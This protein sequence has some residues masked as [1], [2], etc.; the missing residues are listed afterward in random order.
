MY[1]KAIQGIV[2]VYAKKVENR[3]YSL[4]QKNKMAFGNLK[5]FAVFFYFTPEPNSSW[6][7][8][9]MQ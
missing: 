2:K 1:Y 9:L 5:L 6:K 7:R 3:F 8:T 4:A